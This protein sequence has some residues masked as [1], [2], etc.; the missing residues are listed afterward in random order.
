AGRVAG[1]LAAARDITTQKRLQ[2]QLRDQQNYNRG[3]IEASV[4]ALLTVGPDGI[5]A[6]VNEQAVKLSG[7]GRKQLVGTRFSECFTEPA[8]AEAGVRETFD[9]GV[10]INY[11]LVLRTKVGRKL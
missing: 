6:D 5:I 1:I 4:D 3:L 7:Y 9:R 8:R 10:V 11:E 2:E